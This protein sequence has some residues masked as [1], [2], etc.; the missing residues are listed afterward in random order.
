VIQ[1][2]IERY[3]KLNS[4]FARRFLEGLQKKERKATLV[5][6]NDA[7][8]LCAAAVL[9]RAFEASR[10]YHDLL[11]IEK[12]HPAV[13]EKIFSGDED[14][15]FVFLDLGGQ[16]PELI[17]R[18]AAG[19]RPVLILDHHL[20]SQV[21]PESI[22]CINPEDFGISGDTE[23]S[24]ASVAAFFAEQ[25]LA[26]V[27]GT[28]CGR[29]AGPAA[30][31]ASELNAELAAYGIIGAYGDR[32]AS[33]NRFHGANQLLFTTARK[34]GL[35]EEG[36]GTVRFPSFEPANPEKIVEI[37]DSLGSIG[38]YSGGARLGVR[39]LLGRDRQ[40]ALDT[41]A[42]LIAEKYRL[43]HDKA[44][45]IRKTGLSKSRHFQWIDVHSSFF[46]MGV[47]AIGLFLEHLLAVEIPDPYR[48][49][50][51]F[52]HF[53][54]SQP[55]IGKLDLSCTKVSSRVPGQ[56]KRR[57]QQDG[58]PDYMRL[59]PEAV[60]RIG[61]IADGCHRFAAAALIDRGR[62]KELIRALEDLMPAE[63]AER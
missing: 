18:Y 36:S 17:G 15:Y 16:N 23:I 38:F 21:I 50:L 27:E 41:A 60:E 26:E 32:Q 48:Y 57:I 62:E 25:L 43:F 9:A 58:S 54:D 13:L 46:P 55:G 12:L 6:H 34:Q 52:Q 44:D 20:P 3:R 47:K 22:L 63:P 28:R 8:G 33:D 42:D 49:L 10:I 37:L 40:L 2:Q 11:P 14:T 51:G 24:G 39:F 45:Q 5:H 53:P 19:N 61:G 35:I 29:A 59:L 30:R 31:L 1:R 7:D 4:E 56:L